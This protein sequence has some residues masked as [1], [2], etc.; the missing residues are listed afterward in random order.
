MSNYTVNE[1][2]MLFQA[3]DNSI[4]Y[5]L[6]FGKVMSVNLQNYPTKLTELGASF[7][8]LKIDDELR[9]CI[10]S[11]EA[12]QA[13]IVDVVHNAF[14]SAFCDPRFCPLTNAEY[15]RLT[16]HISILSK[17]EP[18]FFV[19]EADLLAQLRPKIDGLV[20]QEKGRCG[21]FLPIVWEEL[22]DPRLFLQCLKT[23]AG[24][25]PDYWS[26]SIKVFRYTTEL[27]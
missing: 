19:S 22:P 6:E 9:G 2:Q 12:S 3:A 5:G 27:I 24:L 17:P 25:P 4:K 16:I 7:V 21:T 8:T 1:K 15:S 20:L 18:L 10:G 14:A 13:L 11:L 26:G 23:K